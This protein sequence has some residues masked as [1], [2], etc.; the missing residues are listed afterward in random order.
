M[1]DP[2]G[3]HKALSRSRAFERPDAERLDVRLLALLPEQSSPAVG[4]AAR[5]AWRGEVD[6]GL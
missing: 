2:F 4:A 6:I 3:Q 5:S 1:R